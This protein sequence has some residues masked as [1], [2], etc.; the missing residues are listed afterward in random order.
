[1]KKEFIK[2]YIDKLN[3]NLDLAGTQFKIRKPH[4]HYA[5]VSRKTTD[6]QP[7]VWNFGITLSEDDRITGVRDPEIRVECVTNDLDGDSQFQGLKQNKSD[8]ERD[9]GQALKWDPVK[10]NR[11]QCSIY[12]NLKCDFTDEDDWDRQ[13]KWLL[14][15]LVKMEKVMPGYIK[16]L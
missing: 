5:I 2:K 4:M 12:I 15:K 7:T 3:V 14:E 1:M 9:F 10:P 16:D 11:N 8:I 13:H 6:L